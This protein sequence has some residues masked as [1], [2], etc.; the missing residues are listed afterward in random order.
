MGLFE[1]IQSPILIAVMIIGLVLGIVGPNVGSA[2]DTLVYFSIIVL[3]YSMALGVPLG[4]VGRSYR[5][6]RFFAIAW[7]LNFLVIPLIA[8]LLA[9]TFLGAYPA[10]YVGF[11]LY[12]VTPCTDWFLVFTSMARGDVP[13][14]LALL[15]T[16]L[17]LQILLLPVYIYAFAGQIIPFQLSAFFE[18]VVV[19]IALPFVLAALTRH[20]LTKVRG[21]ERKKAIIGRI[22]PPLQLA[23]LSVVIFLMFFGQ[24]KV[25]ADNIG[26][27]LIIFIPLLVFFLISYVMSRSVSKFFKLEYKECALLTCTTAARNSPLSL[28]I[29][30]GVFPDQPLIYVAIIIGVLIELPILVLVTKML[31]ASKGSDDCRRPSM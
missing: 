28:A 19:F 6:I 24:S 29:A 8:W 1:K 21:K 22:S 26:P 9:M 10:I 4:E 27:L 7:T 25:I 30:F 5:R 15:P 18:T 3:I 12:L 14:G 23:T 2:V 13:L 11:I 17:A 16:N 20:I 31:T